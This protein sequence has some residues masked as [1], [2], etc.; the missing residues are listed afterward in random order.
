MGGFWARI[1]F[2]GYPKF[3]P[4][5]FT[6]LV[7]ENRRRRLN[8]RRRKCDEG[9]SRLLRVDSPFFSTVGL[10]KK[11]QLFPQ[12]F[13]WFCRKKDAWKEWGR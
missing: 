8:C 5:F 3:R 11:N 6:T 9:S 12:G 7:T 13:G 1:S 2:L 4:S 10:F